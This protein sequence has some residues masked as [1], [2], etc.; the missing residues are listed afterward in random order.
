MKLPPVSRVVHRGGGSL[1]S[2]EGFKHTSWNPT[3]SRVFIS[4]MS[5]IL[6][7]GVQK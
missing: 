3:V 6:G 1:G 5:W 2:E 4:G 7:G